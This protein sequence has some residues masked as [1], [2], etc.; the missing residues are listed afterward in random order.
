M[1]IIWGKTRIL[2]ITEVSDKKLREAVNIVELA[3]EGKIGF[4][5]RE[6]QKIPLHNSEDLT[7]KIVRRKRAIM[8]EQSNYVASIT[9]EEV[10]DL[11]EKLK[12]YVLFDEVS[13]KKLFS[14]YNKLHRALNLLAH[15]GAIDSFTLSGRGRLTVNWY[16]DKERTKVSIEQGLTFSLTDM[17]IKTK[18]QTEKEYLNDLAFGKITPLRGLGG[19]GKIHKNYEGPP[20]G[21]IAVDQKVF[22]Y[23]AEQNVQIPQLEEVD[24]LFKDKT[25]IECWN[26]CVLFLA[27]I[28]LL[29]RNQNEPIRE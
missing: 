20:K 4:C 6:V 16:S 23:R 28:M 15:C 10:K 8:S 24:A 5:Y 14:N 2:Q 25:V 19:D 3:L 7:N 17:S 21:G 29:R 11:K 18:T 9:R 13:R 1:K 22:R 26:H 12:E 27:T